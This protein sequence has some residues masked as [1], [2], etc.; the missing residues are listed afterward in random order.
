VVASD[1]KPS[2]AFSPFASRR[3]GLTDSDARMAPSGNAAC[4]LPPT[5]TV[6]VL[7]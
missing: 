6:N 5:H 3:S 4:F 2:L 1:R 7:T